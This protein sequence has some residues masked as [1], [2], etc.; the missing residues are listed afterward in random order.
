MPTESK[1]EGVVPNN[2]LN[3]LVKNLKVCNPIFKIIGD[4]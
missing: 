3:K 1:D 2:K 4:N